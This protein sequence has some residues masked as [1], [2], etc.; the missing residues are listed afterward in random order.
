MVREL[1]ESKAA[2]SF[3][4]T[5]IRSMGSSLTWLLI[6]ICPSEQNNGFERPSLYKTLFG[7]GQLETKKK[8]EI[9][10]NKF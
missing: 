7:S 9:R 1:T 6:T 2:A 4:P 3:T 10:K 8:T 5:M